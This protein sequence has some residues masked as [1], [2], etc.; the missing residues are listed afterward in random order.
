M[1]YCEGRYGVCSIMVA[2][3]SSVQRVLWSFMFIN[4][5]LPV[6]GSSM[7]ARWLLRKIEDSVRIKHTKRGAGV[8]AVVSH[9]LDWLFLVRV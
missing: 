1:V 7:F 5:L 4:A 2:I 8:Y 9:N 3:L 6:S